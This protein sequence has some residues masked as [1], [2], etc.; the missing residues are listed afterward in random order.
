MKKFFLS[1]YPQI[2]AMQRLS[3]LP[4][5]ILCLFLI[6]CSNSDDNEDLTTSVNKNGS[7]ESSI[8]VAPLDSTHHVLT[9]RHKVWVHDTVYKTIEYRDTLPSL[10]NEITTAENENGDTKTV[11]VKKDYE[12]YITVK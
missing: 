9:T 3:F 2:F 6:S 12:V 8:T 5:S 1:L 4:F 10:G 11:N 7:V